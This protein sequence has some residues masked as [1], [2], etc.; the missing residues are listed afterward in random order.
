MAVHRLHGFVDHP[1]G[2]E[3][4]RLVARA[5]FFPRTRAQ[6]GEA[7]RR[8]IRVPTRA[9]WEHRCPVCQIVRI[10]GRPVPEWRCADCLDAGL[11]GEMVITRIPPPDESPR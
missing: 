1:H 2:P 10:G 4:K 9:R 5:G 8:Q 3:W 6:M 7:A 11:S